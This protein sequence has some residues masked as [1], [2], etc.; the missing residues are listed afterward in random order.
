MKKINFILSLIIS[1]GIIN[2]LKAQITITRTDFGNVGYVQAQAQDTLPAG[3]APGSA[4]TNQTWNLAAMHEHYD[5]TIHFVSPAST[6]FAAN[7][8]ASNIA[9]A[10]TY[11]PGFFTYLNAT[12]NSIKAL[13]IG[14][15]AGAITNNSLTANYNPVLKVDS[16]PCNYLLA[17]NGN[18]QYTLQWDTAITV[19]F[20]FDSIRVR[21]HIADSTAFDGWGNVTTPMG[22]FA[23]LR[24]NNRQHEIDSIFVHSP[25][26]TWVSAGAPTLKFTQKYAWYTNSMGYALCELTMDTTSS[27]VKSATW[28]KVS[29]LSVANSIIREDRNIYPNPAQN[30]ISYMNNDEQVSKL[31]I[32]DA[33]GREIYSCEVLSGLNKL[34]TSTFKN[35]LYIYRMLKSDG[36]V[37]Q[38][39]RFMVN[40]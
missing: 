29:P 10:M 32:Y 18:T 20:T 1:V 36:N 19:P 24:A 40:R 27:T 9:I 26:S 28:L 22:T 4:G 38:S 5:D 2:I 25:P 12:T 39:G 11:S 14:I 35:G 6:P 37:A 8:P 16:F 7:F 23:S 15:P 33:S 34:N 30:E 21:V 3:I 17:F 31:N 13:G